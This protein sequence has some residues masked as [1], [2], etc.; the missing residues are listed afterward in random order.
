M[1]AMKTRK[2][3]AFQLFK[4]VCVLAMLVSLFLVY[5]HFS[6]SAEQFC[7]FGKSFD[8]GIVNKSPYAS[9]DGILYFLLFDMGVQ[10]QLLNFSQYGFLID[11]LTTNAFWGFLTF[12][13]LFLSV[14]AVEQKRKFLGMSVHRQLVVAKWIL[15]L[16][17]LYAIY[18][19][20]IELYVLKT[21]CIFCV[22]LDLLIL[23]ALFLVYKLPGGTS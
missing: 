18:L 15:V 20:Y 16:S 3:R 5:E 4:I 22:V 19:V 10:V 6:E 14:R 23:A 11:L 13:F 8:C 9:I 7:T 12:L 1:S 17:V 21:I 2:K